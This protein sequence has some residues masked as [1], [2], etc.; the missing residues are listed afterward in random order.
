MHETL[1]KLFPLLCICTLWM[2]GLQTCKSTPYIP[3]RC[4]HSLGPCEIPQQH[5]CQI[6][7][8]R[9]AILSPVPLTQLDIVLWK[10]K[11]LHLRIL[12][13]KYQTMQRN[14]CEQ[15]VSDRWSFCKR[16]AVTGNQYSRLPERH[17]NVCFILGRVKQPLNKSLKLI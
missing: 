1:F 12:T 3:Q 2:A 5:A 6:M 8:G 17:Q 15:I 13:D 14:R 10:E 9:H 7:K 16:P 4:K 11:V